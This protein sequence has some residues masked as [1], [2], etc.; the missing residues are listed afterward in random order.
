MAKPTV[1]ITTSKPRRMGMDM[2][3]TMRV[4]RL[5]NF[6]FTGLSA[7]GMVMPVVSRMRMHSHNV[8]SPTFF[9][10]KH[11]HIPLLSVYG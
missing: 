5:P 1:L 6:P 2:I 4:W 10:P 8:H 3:V 11:L 9:L 7:I